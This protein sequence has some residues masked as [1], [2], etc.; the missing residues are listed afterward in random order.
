[1]SKVGF[2]DHRALDAC[3]LNGKRI[4]VKSAK[5]LG[6]TKRTNMRVRVLCEPV[7]INGKRLRKVRYAD[8][9]ESYA[10]KILGDVELKSMHPAKKRKLTREMAR[11]NRRFDLKR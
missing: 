1:M 6:S 10:N 2:Q 4:V 3:G 7:V 11:E 8:S 5:A 9:I